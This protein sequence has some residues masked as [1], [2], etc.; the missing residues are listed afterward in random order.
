MTDFAVF[1]TIFLLSDIHKY[2][3]FA[4][5]DLLLTIYVECKWRLQCVDYIFINSLLFYSKCLMRFLL[6]FNDLARHV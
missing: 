4:Y 6:V 3:V 5:F 2:I 1:V